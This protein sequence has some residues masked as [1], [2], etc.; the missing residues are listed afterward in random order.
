MSRLMLR[1]VSK[2]NKTLLAGVLGGSCFSFN[3]LNDLFRIYNLRLKMY[4]FECNKKF[5]PPIYLYT[6]VLQASAKMKSA[7]LFYSKSR[8]VAHLSTRKPSFLDPW[9]F[10]TE[11]TDFGP[12]KGIFGFGRAKYGKRARKMKE[13]PRIFENPARQ[14]TGCLIG[15]ASRILL[16]N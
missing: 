1:D 16:I 10:L 14:R 15:S 4:H 9:N 6:V 2:N 8:S 12:R 11:F 3:S 5:F 7:K 13:T